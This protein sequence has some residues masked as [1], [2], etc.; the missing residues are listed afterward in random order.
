VLT[1]RKPDMMV[2][3]GRG[4]RT[5]LSGRRQRGIA[6]QATAKDMVEEEAAVVKAQSAER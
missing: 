6:A 5:D 1:A 4:S 2:A 3:W